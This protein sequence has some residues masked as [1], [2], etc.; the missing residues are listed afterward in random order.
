MTSAPVQVY[1]WQVE[2]PGPPLDQAIAAADAIRRRF[3]QAAAHAGIE[4]LPDAFHGIPGDP[5]HGHA[6]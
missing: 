4:R 1:V 6:F 5:E 2:Q 3:H